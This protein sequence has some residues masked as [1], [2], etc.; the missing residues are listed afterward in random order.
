MGKAVS[1]FLD[2]WLVE[3]YLRNAFIFVSVVAGYVEGEAG[4]CGNGLDT[5]A[6]QARRV[7]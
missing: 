5:A 2:N 1:F 6:R 4:G 3:R 7:R